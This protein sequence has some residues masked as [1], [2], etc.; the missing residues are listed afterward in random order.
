MS[1][2]PL[3]AIVTPSLNAAA[4]I[5]RTIGSVLQQ[6]YPHIEYLVMDGG[7]SDATLEI[8]GR[9]EGRLQYVS[10]P[11]GGQA[12]AVN[13]GFAQTRGEILAFVNADD[14]LLPGAVTTAV[15]TFANRPDVSVVY[16]NGV[17]IDENDAPVV[18]YPVEPFDVENL[19]RRCFICQPAAFFRREAFLA[20]GG[21]DPALRFAL[22]YDLWIRMA[23]HSPPLT[24]VQI[25]QR[26]AAL[27]LHGRA[28]T[29]SEMGPALREAI[30]VLQRHY[31]Y[32][33]YNW[34]YGY[35]HHHLT[36]QSLAVDKPRPS[37]AS[38]CYSM[39]MG[40]RYNWRHP[41][42]FCRDIVTTARQGL[43]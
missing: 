17:Y 25:D 4:F 8:L 37:L 3:V 42:R 41:L 7:S 23:R 9:F 33:P 43:A 39:A 35:G 5:E 38:A 31:G 13:R 32:V 22:D 29:M 1:Q 34:L 24:M 12:A 28:K 14:T 36:G 11:D 19:A 16:G 27:R 15:H 26:L 30:S 10:G 18:P 21:L 40:A 20:V 2:S 6:D